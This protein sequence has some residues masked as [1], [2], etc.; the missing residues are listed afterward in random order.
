MSKVTERWGW[1]WPDFYC[2]RSSKLCW[3]GPF[4]TDAFSG[5]KGIG[6]FVAINVSTFVIKV[7]TTITIMSI[8]SSYCSYTKHRVNA[9]INAASNWSATVRNFTRVSW[10]CNRK[11]YLRRTQANSQSQVLGNDQLEEIHES[12]HLQ[13]LDNKLDMSCNN[14]VRKILLK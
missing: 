3:I 10:K 9:R 7:Y 1:G 11:Q 12:W 4:S 13:E 2:L 8:F 6:N 14:T 5:L